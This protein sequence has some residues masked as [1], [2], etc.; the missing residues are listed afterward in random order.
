LFGLSVVARVYIQ[1]HVSLE[2][3]VV[4]DSKAMHFLR[5]D[6]GNIAF[7]GNYGQQK[8]CVQGSPNENKLPGN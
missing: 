3:V 6:I 4:L 1:G 5:D 2:E 8:Q 7:S